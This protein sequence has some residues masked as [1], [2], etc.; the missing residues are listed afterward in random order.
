M[1]KISLT[2]KYGKGKSLL[3]DDEDYEKFTC[4]GLRFRLSN[5]GYVVFGGNAKAV[6]RIIMNAPKGTFID[7]INHDKLDNRKSNLRICT[8]QQNSMNR[9]PYKGKSSK[10]K[11]VS[12]IKKLDKFQAMIQANGKPKFLGRFKT[13][14]EAA[15]K[16]NEAALEYFGEFAY[17]NDI[18]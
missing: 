10:Y 14:E 7:H 8:N 17:L 15:K 18:K 16:Y 1:K 4:M 3:L 12:Y 2:G 13:E 11:G 5:E 9:K 6:H